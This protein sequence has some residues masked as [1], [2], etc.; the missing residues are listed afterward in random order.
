MMDAFWKALLLGLASPDQDAGCGLVAMVLGLIG[1][2][3]FIGLL[4]YT[5]V[6]G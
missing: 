2:F 1:V 3:F 5:S 4:L 6:A